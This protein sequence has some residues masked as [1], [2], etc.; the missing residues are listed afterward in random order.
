VS[1]VTGAPAT[2]PVLS[3]TNGI[4]VYAQDAK[5]DFTGVDTT[6]GNLGFINHPSAE[7]VWSTPSG[8]YQF[9]TSQQPVQVTVTLQSVGDT[10][11]VIGKILPTANLAKVSVASTTCP[12]AGVPVG[13]ACTVTITYDPSGIPGG[14]NPYT[15]YD[16]MTVTLK[17]NSGLIPVFS[18][19]FETPIAP[20]G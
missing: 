20:G 5:G 8:G 3:N 11:L 6:A 4:V 18:E 10:P 14:D 13:A 9:L 2:P 7:Y 1:Q 16:T 12:K 17:S 15:A 19:R